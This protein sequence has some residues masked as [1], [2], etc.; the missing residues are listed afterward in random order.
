MN[1]FKRDPGI[2]G[3][4]L[5]SGTGDPVAGTNVRIFN[6]KGALVANLWTDSDGW[7]MWTFKFSGKTVTYTVKVPAFSLS[8]TITMTSKQFVLVNFWVP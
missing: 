1:V 4:V 6:A 7:Y 2:A 8:Q 5:H 3:L